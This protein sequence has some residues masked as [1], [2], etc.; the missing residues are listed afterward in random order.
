MVNRLA[1]GLFALSVTAASACGSE[2]KRSLSSGS[3]GEGG[4]SDGVGGYSP[5]TTGPG[6]AG[7]GG[8][9]SQPPPAGPP[10][11][12]DGAGA[13]F[14]IRKLF[15]GDTDRDGTPNLAN[16][17]MQYGFDIDHKVSDPTSTDLCH[18][19]MGA[20]KEKVYLDGDAG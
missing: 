18:P 1:I 5:A 3:G 12:G 17:W 2:V 6:A 11:P 7:V 16:G 19:A 4:S 8:G 13:T 9:G 14:V 20:L 15:L 10:N